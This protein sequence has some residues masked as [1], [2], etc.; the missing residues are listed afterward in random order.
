MGGDSVVLFALVGMVPYLCP[1]KRGWEEG[2]VALAL[3][4]KMDAHTLV[5]YP[6]AHHYIKVVP[7]T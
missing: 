4:V 1:E 6:S 3:G 7:P 2:K 5:T